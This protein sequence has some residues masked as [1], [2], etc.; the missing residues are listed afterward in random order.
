MDDKKK[1][2]LLGHLYIDAALSGIL[3]DRISKD[4]ALAKLSEM[5]DKAQDNYDGSER[6]RDYFAGQMKALLDV[7]D[8]IRE[9]EIGDDS[10]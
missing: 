4:N 1:K 2:E 10:E 5:L 6:D 9:L 8:M 3:N 7:M